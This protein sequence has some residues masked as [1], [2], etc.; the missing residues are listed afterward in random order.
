M[1]KLFT[2][3]ALLFSATG[4]A[5]N[6]GIG[7]T[8]P[9]D[10]KLQV[11]RADS[12]ILLLQNSTTT[13]INKT[14]MFFKTGSYYSGSI[15]TI[16]SGA[17]FRMGLFTYG[18]AVPSDLIERIS[19]L[20]GGN[21][22]IGTT[23]PAAKLDING[24]LRLS[25][26]SPGAGKFLI[27]DN[28]G[29]ASWYDLSPSLL[30][31]GASGNTLRHNGTGW[32]ANNIIYNNGTNVGIGTTSPGYI[33]DVNGRMRLRDNGPTAT[34]GIW[35][36]K[37]DNTEAAFIGM[38]NDSTYGYFG[39]GNWRMGFDVKN[40]QMGIGIT[41][42]SAPLSFAS[43]IGNKISLWGDAT[44]GHY[45]LGIQGSLMQ[46]YTSGSNADIVLGYGSSSAFT[47]NMRVK[48]NGNV[49]IGTNNPNSKLEVKTD[50]YG[51]THTGGSVAVQ[52]GSYIDASGGWLGTNSNHPLHF[53]TNNSAQQ[54]TLLA[55]GNVGIGTIAP[56]I[57]GLV[58]NKVVGNTNAVFGANTAGVSIQSNYPGIGFNTYYNA[59]SFMISSGGAGYI[60]VDPTNSKIIL[61][62]T[63]GNAAAGAPTFLQDKMW[64][65]YDGT[66]S[67]GS[68]NLNA[69]NVSLGSGYKLKVYGK[70]IS[71]E[72]RV[73]L[74]AAWPDYVFEND[75]KKLSLSDLEKFVKENKHL[76]NVPTAKEIE[77]DGQHL[78]E[79]QLKLLEKVEEL[80]LYVIELKK[81]I[82]N[83]KKK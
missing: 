15:A 8:A 34:P 16:G 82:D 2:G 68:S 22:G 47:E 52:V 24:S 26:G 10:M 54:M 31:A 56:V 7:E 27:S 13:G 6:V 72:V 67:L 36:N 66:V 73:Q 80:T 32:I 5:Q 20:D 70:I 69:E 77:K 79:I 83:L 63:G 58:V 50:G 4:F 78:G 49:G 62:N 48:G 23:T 30:P 33:L 45:G 81:E 21:V 38:V 3:I 76:P 14:G 11:K 17:T 51:F 19:I 37:A 61:S 12:A 60:G 39:N 40:A 1:K 25:G 75:Y 29:F 57:G 9:A 65:E 74:K 64:I 59:G 46:L 53:Y 71:E 44:G 55:N 18:G 28:T 35:H 42:P 43:T 41:D